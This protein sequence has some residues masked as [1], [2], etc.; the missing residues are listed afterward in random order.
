MVSAVCIVCVQFN[1]IVSPT[2][3]CCAVGEEGEAGSP[4]KKRRKKAEGNP[5]S[6]VEKS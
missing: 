5:R 4:R 1:V 3:L 2:C 6:R